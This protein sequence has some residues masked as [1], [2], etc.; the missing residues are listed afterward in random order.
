MREVDLFG[1][2]YFSTVGITLMRYKIGI[3][4]FCLFMGLFVFNNQNNN[5]ILNQ[6]PFWAACA[7]KREKNPLKRTVLAV[8]RRE[9]EL[10]L[11]ALR[12]DPRPQC[13]L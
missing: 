8:F 6:T 12:D 9:V 7:P 4:D 13:S 2:S 10:D 5:T 3:Y 11:V 1:Y